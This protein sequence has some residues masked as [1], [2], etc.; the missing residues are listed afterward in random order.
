MSGKIYS[1]DIN[2]KWHRYVSFAKSA[3][4][5]G[6]FYLL[7]TGSIFMAGLGLIA[8]EGLGILEELV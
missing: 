1:L 2:P 5:I 4:R 7:A 8:A 3:V 6:S